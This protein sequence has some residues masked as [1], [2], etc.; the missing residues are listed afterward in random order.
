MSGDGFVHIHEEVSQPRPA[1]ENRWDA[2]RALAAFIA[3]PPDPDALV[4]GLPRGGIPVGVSLADAFACPLDTLIVCKLPI[5][6]HPEW[7]SAR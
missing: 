4:L 2:G 3:P 7:D 1:F 5:P 6:T